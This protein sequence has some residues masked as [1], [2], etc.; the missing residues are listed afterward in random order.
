MLFQAL[1]LLTAFSYPI[2]EYVLSC[3]IVLINTHL[4]VS[5]FVIVYTYIPKEM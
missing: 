5:I 3:K 1:N 4:E 2:Y